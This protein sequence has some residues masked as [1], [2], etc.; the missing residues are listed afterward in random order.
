MVSTIVMAVIRKL[1]PSECQKSVTSMASRKF[2]RLQ[3]AG[4]ERMPWME[5]V[6]SL[7][8][9]KAM[10]MVMYSGNRTVTRPRMSRMVTGQL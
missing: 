8:C 4:R 1:L 6:I 9:L 2:S 7:G 3:C 5:L 10:T